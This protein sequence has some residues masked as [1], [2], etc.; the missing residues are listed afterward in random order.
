MK[1]A[2]VGRD[3]A[4]NKTKSRTYNN[5]QTGKEELYESPVSSEQHMI[6]FICP[7]RQ[8]SKLTLEVWFKGLD[9]PLQN[10]LS[11]MHAVRGAHRTEELEKKTESQDDVRTGSCMHF[12]FCPTPLT[13]VVLAGTHEGRL[14][15]SAARSLWAASSGLA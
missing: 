8:E 12:W 13:V 6:T 14:A 3:G 1:D 10:Q 5:I 2:F 7:Q 4:P 15:E 11:R 9:P